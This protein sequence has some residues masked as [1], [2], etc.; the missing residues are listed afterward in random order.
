MS[1]TG[2]VLAAGRSSR[3]DCIK[4]LVELE[5][6][7]FVQRVVDALHEGGC[8]EV[9]VVVGPPHEKTIVE[10]L[11]GVTT[12]R[13]PQPERGMLSSLQRGL[14]HEVC[15]GDAIVALVDQPRIVGSTV[16]ALIEAAEKSEAGWLRPTFEGRTGHPYFIRADVARALREADD[17]HSPRDILRIFEVQAVTVQDPHVLDDFDTAEDLAKLTS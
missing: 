3:A 13:N 5:G 11:D 14:S 2:I 17:R 8:N 1:V 16:G 4:A 15:D 7:S 12:V 6:R 9:L 10:T